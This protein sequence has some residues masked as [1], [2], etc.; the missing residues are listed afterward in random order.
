MINKAYKIGEQ[1]KKLKEEKAGLNEA[2]CAYVT[3]RSMEGYAR[4]LK[5]YSI[6]AVKRNLMMC[7]KKDQEFDKTFL[8]KFLIVE[9]A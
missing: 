4:F 7:C 8:G 9:E 1:Y 3:F 6:G 5:V 2:Q